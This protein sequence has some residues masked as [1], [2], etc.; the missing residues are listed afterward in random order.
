MHLTFTLGDDRTTIRLPVHHQHLLQAVAYGL[1]PPAVAARVHDRGVVVDGRPFRLFT[2]SRLYGTFHRHGAVLIY[3]GPL[4]WTLASPWDDVMQ[5]VAERALRHGVLWLGPQPVS[6]AGVQCRC[7][8]SVGDRIAV[9]TLSPVSVHQTVRGPDGKAVTRY[10][11]PEEPAYA[12]LVEGNLRRKYQ[13][14]HGHPAPAPERCVHLAPL[15]AVREHVVGYQGGI[16]KG[17]SG[18][19]ALAGPPELLRVALEAGLGSR[20]A[21]G[22]GC[23]TLVEAATGAE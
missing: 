13:A 15:G 23:I 17:V 4:T 10:L 1:F 20:T 12:A 11:A 3:V 6:V 22:F 2:F 7:F 16:V 19:F 5:A 21:Q 9:R 14:W 18:R 8:P